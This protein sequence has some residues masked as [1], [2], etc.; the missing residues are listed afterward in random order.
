MHSSLGNFRHLSKLHFVLHEIINE[1]INTKIKNVDWDKIEV[2]LKF[3][4]ILEKSSNQPIVSPI[5]SPSIVDIGS[6]YLF[7]S[8]IFLRHYKIAN[9]C[10][11]KNFQKLIDIGSAAKYKH[12]KLVD[13]FYIQNNLKIR[14][15]YTNES[16]ISCI[17]KRKICHIHIHYPN[18]PYDVRITISTENPIKFDDKGS[19]PL[20]S[21]IKDRMSYIYQFFIIEL[22]SVTDNSNSKYELEIEFNM[23][24]FNPDSIDECLNMV[25]WLSFHFNK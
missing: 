22:T 14:A 10:M 20:Y 12:Q 25:D 15:T 24:S 18:S 8:F 11:N 1:E 3:G 5:L 16:L 9:E 4:K 19:T 13:K 2:E 6:D 21:R 7:E 23:S 17:E